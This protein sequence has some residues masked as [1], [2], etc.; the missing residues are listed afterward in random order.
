MGSYVKLSLER[1]KDKTGIE[2]QDL[3]PIKTKKAAIQGQLQS[4]PEGGLGRGH[5]SPSGKML[6]KIR[7]NW[8]LRLIPVGLTLVGTRE[9]REEA[10][11]PTTKKITTLLQIKQM[12]NISCK[13]VHPVV[14]LE[15]S[16]LSFEG[17]S[18]PVMCHSSSRVMKGLQALERTYPPNFFLF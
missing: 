17:S 8:S 10:S 3:K 4:W 7:S 14:S 12:G 18:A 15:P 13:V 1:N 2:M 5:R 16:W 11:C 9:R 6:P